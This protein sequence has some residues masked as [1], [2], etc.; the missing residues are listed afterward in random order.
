MTKV[1]LVRHAAHDW[2]SRGIPGRMAGVGLN[3]LGRSQAQELAH[4]LAGVRIDAIYSSP[5]Q[6]ARETVAPLASLRAMPVESAPEFDEIDFGDWTGRA[7]SDLESGDCERWRR[8]VE[9]RSAAQPPAG[10]AFAQVAQRAMAGLQ[11]LRRQHEDQTVLVLSHGDV[12]KAALASC[13]GLSLDNLERF[14]VEPASVSV[15]AAAG[16]A[17][18]VLALNQAQAGRVPSP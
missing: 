8:W 9:R 16:G 2:L 12:I 5:Q 6:R 18:K 11:R 7:F 14:D 17:W 4:R 13:L 1:L 15:V 3:A 10:E